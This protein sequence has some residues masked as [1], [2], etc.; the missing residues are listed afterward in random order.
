M[1]L[2]GSIQNRTGEGEGEEEEEEELIQNR[3]G[4]VILFKKALKGAAHRRRATTSA[5][6]ATIGCQPQAGRMR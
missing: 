1:S 5:R 3:T 6:R 4:A 2:D